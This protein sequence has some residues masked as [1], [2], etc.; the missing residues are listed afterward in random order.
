[1]S[2]V[3]NLVE[4]VVTR[5]V[6]GRA[7]SNDLAQI[8]AVPNDMIANSQQCGTFNEADIRYHEAVLTLMHNP[9]LQ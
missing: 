8:E 6:A 5:W 2:E 3:Y 7:A 9:V 4:P 1:M